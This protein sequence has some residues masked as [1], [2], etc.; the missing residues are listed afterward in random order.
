MNISWP[1][2]TIADLFLDKFVSVC[3][4]LAKAK[5]VQNS[6]GNLECHDLSSSVSSK[7]FTEIAEQ[8]ICAKV[9]L[10]HSKKKMIRTWRLWHSTKKT[11]KSQTVLQT[12]ASSVLLC[13]ILIGHYWGW[14][15]AVCT[16][17]STFR[18]QLAQNLKGAECCVDRED[19]HTRR[20]PSR[21][22][23]YR[24]PGDVRTLPFTCLQNKMKLRM[25][26]DVR[27]TE[28]WISQLSSWS[29]SI[30]CASL[31][32]RKHM[33]TQK[34]VH[35]SS[36]VHI[37][38]CVILW[39]PT[40]RCLWHLIRLASRPVQRKSRSKC[41]SLVVGHAVRLRIDVLTE[42]VLSEQ[43]TSSSSIQHPNTETRR[44]DK[45]R[46]HRLR[47]CHHHVPWVHLWRVLIIHRCF[48]ELSSG[49]QSGGQTRTTSEVFSVQ[50]E[51]FKF[52]RSKLPACHFVKSHLF[53]LDKWLP[54]FK[55]LPYTEIHAK[56]QNWQLE[57]H[58][59]HS[60]VTVVC[61]NLVKLYLPL[62]RDLRHQE[63]MGSFLNGSNTSH[64]LWTCWP[65]SK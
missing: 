1:F 49:L 42:W 60:V 4:L 35:R 59:I 52:C 54:I 22:Q 26:N 21:F 38:S 19:Y 57:E 33:E 50:F 12:L 14:W 30:K 31:P 56:F 3:D 58:R 17:R 53:F 13:W 24:S 18:L 55:D 37:V 29:F 34:P 44:I 62:M 39:G 43:V 6:E 48:L 10:G 45:H 16:L 41:R 8:W 11:G 46:F 23:G 63:R 40:C 51:F 28:V 32:N 7:C 15:S 5:D 61:W 27:Q 65:F 47:S 9:E 20:G 64:S 25:W 36:F 2:L